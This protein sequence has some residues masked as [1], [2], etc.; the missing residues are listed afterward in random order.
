[1]MGDILM[2][3]HV[4]WV[5]AYSFESG[6][7]FKKVVGGVRLIALTYLNLAMAMEGT[8]PIK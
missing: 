7:K 1:M 8:L 6:G 2:L 3:C 4:I 5:A